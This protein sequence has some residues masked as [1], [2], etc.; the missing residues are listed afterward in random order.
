ME[1]STPPPKRRRRR[2]LIAGVVLVL[3]SMVVW[4]YWPRG[5]K[6]FVGRWEAS[7]YDSKSQ[8]TRT[9]VLVLKAN[10]SGETHANVLRGGDFA[11]QV[12]GEVFRQGSTTGYRII[13]DTF[14]R[15]QSRLPICIGKF[16]TGYFE[17]NI[18]SV[19][20]DEIEMSTASGGRI[21]FKRLPE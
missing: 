2:W 20:A 15:I 8:L 21:V 6:R 16:P 18:V 3:V 10:G 14:A 5:D 12:R 11:W 9:L 13:D 1:P 4:W 17:I 19:E 7:F